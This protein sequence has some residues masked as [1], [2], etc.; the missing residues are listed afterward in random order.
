MGVEGRVL[1]GGDQGLAH[2]IS[3]PL[4]YAKTRIMAGRGDSANLAGG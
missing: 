1:Q 4:K 3:L 2:G